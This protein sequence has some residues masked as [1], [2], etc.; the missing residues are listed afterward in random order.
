MDFSD[1]SIVSSVEVT[2]AI[3]YPPVRKSET[4]SLRAFKLNPD[5]LLLSGFVS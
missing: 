4:L 3:S 1:L 2:S 5:D